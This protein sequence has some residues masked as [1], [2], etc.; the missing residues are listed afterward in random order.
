MSNWRGPRRSSGRRSQ[1][2]PRS[3]PTGFAA[4]MG[5][6]TETAEPK[7]E[8]DSDAPAFAGHHD[9]T[10]TDVENAFATITDVENAFATVTDVE[11]DV[12]PCRP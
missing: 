8:P 5:A 12:T 3:P 6:M 9:P 1:R 10:I 7:P 2:G 4:T 11:G